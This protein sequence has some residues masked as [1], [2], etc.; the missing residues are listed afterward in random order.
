VLFPYAPE[1]ADEDDLSGRLVQRRPDLTQASIVE[2]YKYARDG[3]VSVT[4]ENATH[5]Y[6]RTYRLGARH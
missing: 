2:T 3:S 5:G 6:A 1:L 4:I